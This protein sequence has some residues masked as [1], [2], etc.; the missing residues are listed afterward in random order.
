MKYLK[1]T[2]KEDLKTGH[3]T[4]AYFGKTAADIEHLDKALISI[5]PFVL[6]KIGPELFGPD[7]NIPVIKYG[8]KD[9]KAEDK[10]GSVRFEILTHNKITDKNYETW[11]P[12][13]TNI[14]DY[15][16]YPDVIHVDGVTTDD[17]ET[18]WEFTDVS[19]ES[20]EPEFESGD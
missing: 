6:T 8:I 4:F 10:V 9:R 18:I 19:A 3:I 16:D 12:H 20:T 1:L 2:T 5:Q 14:P 7:N 15:S 13:I 17:G 11:T